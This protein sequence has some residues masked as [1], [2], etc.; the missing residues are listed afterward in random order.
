MKT[1]HHISVSALITIVVLIIVAC[2]GMLY[3]VTSRM[4]NME[5]KVEIA[6]IKAELS[7]LNQKVSDIYDLLEL[8]IKNEG[9][10]LK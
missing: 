3:G 9:G 10:R 6:I 4:V 1:E 7:L 2:G 5:M 8:R